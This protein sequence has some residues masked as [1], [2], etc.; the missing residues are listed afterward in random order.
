MSAL[1]LGGYLV[2]FL[3]VCWYNYKKLQTMKSA[4][5]AKEATV[6]QGRAKDEEVVRGSAMY[7]CLLHYVSAKCDAHTRSRF[8]FRASLILHICRSLYTVVRSHS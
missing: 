8:A 4:S 5:K 6:Q 7:L 3:A 1:N 2:A